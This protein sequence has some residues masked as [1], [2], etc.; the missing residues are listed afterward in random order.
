MHLRRHFLYGHFL[1]VS[2]VALFYGSM[3]VCVQTHAVTT[4]EHTY[5]SATQ[6]MMP[7]LPLI[8]TKKG[9]ST[10]E[11]GLIMG[12]QFVINIGMRLGVAGVADKYHKHKQLLLVFSIIASCFMSALWW[13]PSRDHEGLVQ[14]R[15]L[16]NCS[17]DTEN[18]KTVTCSEVNGTASMT[19]QAD[20][21]L[22]R[23]TYDEGQIQNMDQNQ[24]GTT[25]N[26]S[27]MFSCE[28]LQKMEI[29]SFAQKLNS[30]YSTI[31]VHMIHFLKKNCI[32]QC[33]E[34]THRGIVLDSVFWLVLWLCCG[35]TNCYVILWALLYGMNYD[36]LGDNK[37]NF[38]R[39][40]M[41]GTLGA[42]LMAVVSA[43]A[44][45]DYRSKKTEINYAP[46]YVGYAAF[47]IV[48]GII[49][50]FFKLEYKVKQPKMTRTVLRLFKQP[51]LCLLFTI[52]CIMGFLSGA[53]SAFIFVFL[54]QMDASSWIFG[55]ALFIR[56]A[57]QI[58]TLYFT[59]NILKK[60][61][62][63][64]YIYLVLLL[65]S[66]AYVATSF[67]SNPWWELPL[68]ALKSFTFSVGFVALS[69]HTSS[70]TPPAMNATLQALVQSLHYGIGV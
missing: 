6:L 23:D 43:I 37:C 61:G 48:T 58:P 55:A 62:Y 70:I 8:F 27:L 52:I 65:Y 63:V 69:I 45:N 28:S 35:S 12:W 16:F 29:C 22:L 60:L 59:G 20:K 10:T 44:M 38:S 33:T 67:V 64:N 1:N 49:G 56:F 24:Q 50:L 40:R 41:W 39:Q 34:S 26:I 15:P 9:L 21:F 31:E 17:G 53:I 57:C 4:F 19:L 47:V 2:G 51:Q 25:H 36:L 14:T 42:I 5:F 46:C 68:S 66:T 32:V 18:I 13:V 7:F 11:I 30:K 54:R 3:C